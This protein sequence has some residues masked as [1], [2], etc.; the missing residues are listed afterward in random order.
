[1]EKEISELA[2]KDTQS[3]KKKEKMNGIGTRLC[4]LCMIRII[5]SAVGRILQSENPHLTKNWRYGVEKLSIWYEKNGI[6]ST[7][8]L[9]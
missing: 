1:M 5:V 3:M 9:I 7:I 8:F 6:N 2:Y 4:F